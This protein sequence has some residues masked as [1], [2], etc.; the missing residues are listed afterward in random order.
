MLKVAIYGITCENNRMKSPEFE[1]A[2]DDR[3]ESF[4]QVGT[5][6]WKVAE[7]HC[8]VA[9][10]DITGR[11]WQQMMGLLRE[12][13][14]LVDDSMV[15]QEDVVERLRNFTEFEER[16]P[17]LSPDALGEES[18]NAL[19][20]RTTR[21]L[22]VGSELARA[23][24]IQRFVALRIVEGRETARLLGDAATITVREQNAF[25]KSFL[26]TMES[27]AVTANLIDSVT[28]GRV[29]YREGKI[30]RRPNAEYYR[31]LLAEI[32]GSAGL[33]AKALLHVP[34][35]AEF[36]TMSWNRLVN[37]VKHQDS[38]TTSLRNFR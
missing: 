38:A 3:A 10:D 33:G 19:L 24:G 36:A 20:A 31:A 34:V 28:D 30:V 32:P 6:A 37:R 25:Q 22:R 35:L 7:S 26:P 23:A 2:V 8:S 18:Q 5:V 21:I 15:G 29:D 14:T 27:L 17:D 9:M 13:D 12:V 16:Y 11:R 4:L 1:H